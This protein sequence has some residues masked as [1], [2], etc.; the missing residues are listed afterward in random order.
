MADRCP[1]AVIV[2]FGLGNIYSLKSACLSVGFETM[3][4][5]DPDPIF[6]S[7]LV[8]LP[9]V[10]A[11]GD[12]MTS[13]TR[14]S[15]CEPLRDRAE[16]GGPILGICLGMQL[17]MSESEELGRWNGLGI[18]K[19]SVRRLQANA[20]IPQ[21]GWNRILPSPVGQG[22]PWALSP[23]RG[24][25]E[26]EYMYFVH[27]FHVQPEDPGVVLA[28]TVYGG[29]TYCSGLRYKNVF[30]FQFHPERSGPAGI[31]VYRNLAQW[32]RLNGLHSC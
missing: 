24:I 2:D 11:F 12:A 31:A 27:A 25:P 29:E 23:L 10:G 17:L 4:S 3:V 21:V 28:Q 1:T 30:G 26:G 22:P 9:G 8:I 18:V 6:S 5:S 32:A 14:L 13:L 16:A 7:D 15:L 20:K 19:G